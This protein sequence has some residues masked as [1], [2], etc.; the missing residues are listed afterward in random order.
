ME[1]NKRYNIKNILLATLWVVVGAGT[2]VLLV[3]AVHKKDS[4][5]CKGIKINISGASNNFFI[6]KS[7]VQKVITNYAGTNAVGRPIE[8]FNLVA[9]EAVLKKDVWIK[10]AQLFFDNNEILQADVEEREPVARVFTTG[11]NTFYVD[12]SNMMLPLS[13][14]FSARLPVFTGFPSDAKVLL[15]A[16]SNLLNDIKTI[17]ILIQQDSFLMAMIDQVDI[18]AERNF[19]MIPKLGNQV[20]VFGDATD[21][22]K[23]FKK[24]QLF[25]K[26]VM[27][28]AGWSKYSII[29][30]QYKN[31]VVAKIKGKDDV[32]AD[33]L[34]TRQMME[35]IA[36]N[37]A[38]N[39]E[40]SI[41]GVMQA[42]RKSNDSSMIQ[43]SMQRDE[44]GEISY[45]DE[46]PKP[47]GNAAALVSKPVE[48]PVEKPVTKPVQKPTATV[49]K[50]NHPAAAKPPVVKKP[51]VVKPKPSNE[52]PKAVMPKKND[53]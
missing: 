29:S 6:D 24:L 52:K 10:D 45:T 22:D 4:K 18:T 12:N 11:G 28:N 17:S 23:K 21:A 51:A 7:D 35:I 43:Q 13:E 47:Q 41:H 49:V 30:L 39:A 32:S 8:D 50:T 19:E 27:L 5:H 44:T 34:R 25:Y 9:M 42:E 3:A 37:A 40:D 1:L 38:R 20:I 33:S 14:K 48:K 46:E 2:I 15:K 36:A 26:K 16:D 53:Y 31:Q